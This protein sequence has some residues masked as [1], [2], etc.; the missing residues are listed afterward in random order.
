MQHSVKGEFTWYVPAGKRIVLRCL[1]A[2]NTTGAQGRVM[3]FGGAIVLYYSL[4]PG[5]S[6]ITPVDMRC[7]LYEGERL[8]MYIYDQDVSVGIT[9]YVFDDPVGRNRQLSREDPT[10]ITRPEQPIEA[11][12]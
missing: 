4:V 2:V 3:V 12:A 6:G 8:S 9:G 1:T 7:T 11:A 5:S 10:P